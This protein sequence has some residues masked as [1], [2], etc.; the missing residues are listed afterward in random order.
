[1]SKT[2]SLEGKGKGGVR[3]KALNIKRCISALLQKTCHKKQVSVDSE[4]AGDSIE[5]K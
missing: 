1:M 5:I 3:D 4:K 2:E